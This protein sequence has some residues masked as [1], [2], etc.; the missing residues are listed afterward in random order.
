MVFA[1]ERVR[2]LA[3]A[4]QQCWTVVL[5]PE[6]TIN[7]L[8]KWASHALSQTLCMLNTGPYQSTK[9]KNAKTKNT[10][11]LSQDATLQIAWMHSDPFF[12]AVSTDGILLELTPEEMASP[13]DYCYRCFLP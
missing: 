8:Q 3:L 6:G 13:I 9:T 4:D 1:G 11:K 5:P 7:P 12:V 10:S 2:Q